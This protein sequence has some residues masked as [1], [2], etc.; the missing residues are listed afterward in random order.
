MEESIQE[1][2]TGS[3][4]RFPESGCR[5]IASTQPEER[6]DRVNPYEFYTLATDIKEVRAIPD[7]TTVSSAFSALFGLQT[8]LKTLVGRPWSAHSLSRGNAYTVLERVQD[9][10]SA[11][12]D[13][14]GDFL[15]DGRWDAQIPSWVL[16]LLR[17]DI[18]KFEH[19]LATEMES[20][21]IYV[22]EKTSIYATSDLVNGASAAL[23]EEAHKYIEEAARSELNQAGLCLAFG[24]PTASGF[25]SVRAV[26]L[27]LTAYYDQF[28]AAEK[29]EKFK[30]IG[31]YVKELE[32]LAHLK[33]A[34]RPTPCPDSKT[35]RCIDQ[36]RGLDRNPIMHPRESLTE[37]EAIILFNNA[38]SAIWSMTREIRTIAGEPEIP[39]LTAPQRKAVAALT[40]LKPGKTAAPSG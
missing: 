35:V 27:V 4:L 28:P 19:V 18:D 38:I 9:I 29:S 5:V 22:V 39:N 40:Q 24:L 12:M 11:I 3:V 37:G 14:N 15:K 1:N 6:M 25:H 32:R 33:G 7:N 26:E 2:T 10:L 34:A 23:P 20:A 17:A 36:I 30:T 8:K 31:E 13:E 16:S 21:A